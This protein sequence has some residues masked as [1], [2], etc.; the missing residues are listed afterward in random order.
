MEYLS[1][2]ALQ[3]QAEHAKSTEKVSKLI[4]HHCN[5]NDVTSTIVSSFCALASFTQDG[6][7][8]GGNSKAVYPKIIFKEPH[9]GTW[10]HIQPDDFLLPETAGGAFSPHGRSQCLCFQFL[11]CQTG[12]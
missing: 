9:Q 10:Y 4:L 8:G 5:I 1:K 12:W 11:L 6:G 2:N 7:R 3:A